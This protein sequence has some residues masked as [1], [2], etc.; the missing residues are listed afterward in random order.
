VTAFC[1]TLFQNFSWRNS[2]DEAECWYLRVQQHASLIFK[3]GRRIRFVWTRR[4]QGGEMGGKRRETPIE[5]VFIRCSRTF[6]FHRYPQVH[7]ERFRCQ[8]RIC[9]ITSLIASGAKP[10]APNDP[11]PPKLETAAVSLYDDSPP[12]GL[13]SRVLAS[14]SGRGPENGLKRPGGRSHPTP[15]GLASPVSTDALAG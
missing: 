2:V 5:G 3:S 9:A 12:S 11:S 6:V 15:T 1:P 14:L 8:E 7:C 10:C 4:S 13:R